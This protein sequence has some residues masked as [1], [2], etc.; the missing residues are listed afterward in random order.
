MT[1]DG[2]YLLV[3]GEES[4]KNGHEVCLPPLIHI[5][6]FT[7]SI[8][9]NEMRGR[10]DAKKIKDA[11]NF[12]L[13]V[14]LLLLLAPPGSQPTCGSILV[15]FLLY[16]ST[17]AICGSVHSTNRAIHHAINFSQIGTKTYFPPRST[18]KMLNTNPN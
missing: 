5:L 7:L 8:S 18:E 3:R 11:T 4:H 2:Q 16:Y 14:E 6:F 15:V 17:A 13:G 12:Q 1:V 9:S 10:K